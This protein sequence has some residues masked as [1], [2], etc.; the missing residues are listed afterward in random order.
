MLSSHTARQRCRIGSLYSPGHTCTLTAAVIKRAPTKWTHCRSP[1][2]Y[3]A[4]F[5]CKSWALYHIIL[6]HPLRK[7]LFIYWSLILL[8]GRDDESIV[9]LTFVIPNTLLFHNTYFW[10]HFA[11]TCPVFHGFFKRFLCTIQTDCSYILAT[12]NVSDSSPLSFCFGVLELEVQNIGICFR[13]Y[14]WTRQA[15]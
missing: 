7:F 1:W 6:A 13:T 5:Q 15:M 8:Q 9:T 10:S 4:I 2:P 14:K 12:T 11:A 3:T